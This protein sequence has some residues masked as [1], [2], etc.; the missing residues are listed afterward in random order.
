MLNQRSFDM[1]CNIGGKFF[2][3]LPDFDVRLGQLAVTIS[4]KAFCYD[5]AAHL[6]ALKQMLL[7]A[8]ITITFDREDEA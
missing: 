1:C 7:D 2:G 8:D 6:P 5:H 4:P 3:N